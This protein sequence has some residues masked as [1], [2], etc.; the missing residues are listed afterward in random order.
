MSNKL[1]R[2]LQN[3]PRILNAKVNPIVKG[4]FEAWSAGDGQIEIEIQNTKD[5]L[6]VLTAEAEFLDRLASNLGVSR[7]PELG[8]LDED[9]RKLIPNLSLKAK[10]IRSIFYDTMDVFFG[11]LFSRANLNSLNVAP[12]DVS[13]GDSLVI[14]VDGVRREVGVRSDDIAIPGAATAEE[15]VNIINRISQVTA[16]VVDE[17]FTGDERV[18]IRTNT[19]GARGSL[20]ILVES[21]M[22][23]PTKLDFGLDRV[24]ILDLNQR[25]ALYEVNNREIIIELPA[26]VPTL[27]RTLRGSH[28]FHADATLKSPEPPNNGIWQ[29]SFAFSPQGEP[30][31]ITSQRATLQ[32]NVQRSDVYVNLTVD[33]TSELPNEPGFLVF[34][35]GRNNQESPIPYISI[36]NANT[37]L[38]DPSYV[39]QENHAPG[40]VINYISA[41]EAYTPNEDGSDLAIYLTSPADARLAV[42]RLLETLK[43]AGVVI[44]FIILLP[45][46]RY[47][48]C[49]N[50]FE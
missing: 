25:T 16:T 38:M 44:R 9:F 36:P 41:R 20:E 39:F 30:F 12:Y 33:D 26:V 46:Y 13:P 37:I 7:P 35:F 5:Q 3:A 40:T 27:R 10:Q 29:G 24:T 14:L 11:P 43:A 2:Y 45:E 4:L 23:S 18:N 1:D 22:I 28:H 31:T 42:Q 32:Q 50:P 17:Q 34:G 19:T 47:L 49:K 48:T 8:L 15:I 6:F 21:T